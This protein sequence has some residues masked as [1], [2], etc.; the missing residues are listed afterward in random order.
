M[1][2]LEEDGLLLKHELAQYG[3]LYNWFRHN[4]KEPQS[5]T[6]SSKPHAKKVALSWFK[7]TATEHIAKMHEIAHILEAHGI[8]V[9]LLRTERPGYVVY[10]DMYQLTAEPFQETLT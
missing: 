9:N 6:R 1:G 8:G 3:E 5:F 2:S 4:L 10:E 7:D